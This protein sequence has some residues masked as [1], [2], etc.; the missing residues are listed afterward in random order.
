MDER[1]DFQKSRRAGFSDYPSRLTKKI[2]REQQDELERQ[3]AEMDR[4]FVRP[5]ES[6]RS[7]TCPYLEP[8]IVSMKQQAKSSTTPE[9]R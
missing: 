3:L 9:S 4:L 1:A 6:W 7:Q 8:K 5:L 2:Q